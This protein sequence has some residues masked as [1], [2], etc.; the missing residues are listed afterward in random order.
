MVNGSISIFINFSYPPRNIQK[1]DKL[2][3]KVIPLGCDATI[4]H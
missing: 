3:P 4:P 1:T 2:H